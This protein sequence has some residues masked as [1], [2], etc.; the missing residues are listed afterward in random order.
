MSEP[1]PAEKKPNR[2]SRIKSA[3]ARTGND[4]EPFST[5]T[6]TRMTDLE[7][8]FSTLRSEFLHGKLLKPIDEYLEK[9]DRGETSDV[10]FF[11]AIWQF[12]DDED[13][14]REEK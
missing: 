14:E 2:F 7:K 11:G 5:L 8:G 6:G 9:D 1:E 3:F 10:G 4:G 12:S 13:E